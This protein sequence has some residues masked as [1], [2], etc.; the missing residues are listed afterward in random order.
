[1]ALYP[2]GAS[3]VKTNF[4]VSTRELNAIAIYRKYVDQVKVCV[5]SAVMCWLN[6]PE[7]QGD[8]S[9]DRFKPVERI[10]W[11]LYVPEI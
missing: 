4:H 10:Y 6:V 9:G 11:F 1:M 5:E 8:I 2:M 7:Q 3:L